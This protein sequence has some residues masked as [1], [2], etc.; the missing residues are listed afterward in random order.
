MRL[1]PWQEFFIHETLKSLSEGKRVVAINSPTGSGKTVVAL[2]IAKEVLE[3]G[4]ADRVYFAVRTIT[5]ILAPFR[6][7]EKMKLN[8]DASPLIGKERACP[9]GASTVNLC[10]ACSWRDRLA[11]PPKTWLDLFKW[12]QEKLREFKCPYVTLKNLAE[13]SKM[14]ILPYAFLSP[15]IAERVGLRTENSLIIVDEAHN[16]FNFVRERRMNLLWAIGVLSQYPK[17]VR[18]LEK[19]GKFTEEAEEL[20][21]LSPAIYTVINA[22]KALKIYKG[23]DRTIR[24]TE[25]VNAIPTELNEILKVLDKVLP[26]L[27]LDSEPPADI[28]TKIREVVAALTL[29][30]SGEIVPY[31]EREHLTFR[32]VKPW[33]SEYA[34]KSAGLVMLSGTMPSKQ[35]LE[36]VFKTEVTFLDLFAEERLRNEYFKMFKP[37]NVY[38]LV[39]NDYTSAYKYRTDPLMR[40][41]REIVE[42]AI[43]ALTL[44]SGGIGLLVY[45]SYNMLTL[46][47]Q[48]LNELRSELGLEILIGERGSGT[49]I[50]ERAKSVGNCL[51]AVVAGDQV[52]EG[53]EI[54]DERG[55]SMIRVVGI[56][57]AP[58][59]SPSPYLED[60]A[61]WLDK[62]NSEKMMDMIYKEEMLVRVKQAA[63]RLVRHPEDKG[64]V[65][66]ADRRLEEFAND[67][68]PFRPRRTLSSEELLRLVR[69]I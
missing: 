30:G 52:T 15:E 37:D 33:L 8:I 26:P 25:L 28:G 48:H 55:R 56:I 6:D 53:V 31:L 67:I 61:K 41:K 35:F 18:M 34:G 24:V 39:V 17:F 3:R 38:V 36:R 62:E 66:L 16:I 19:L 44:K 13:K 63:G 46:A 58:Y 60:F 32:E 29:V 2:S 49:F 1:R 20:S 51:V 10:P 45:P 23:I 54:T 57:G 40:K 69:E 43:A 9:L 59:P 4:L 7:L 22:L 5:Q 68:A 65:V 42:E 12:I 50:L 27:V 47:K 11:E 64:V 21:A 14:V